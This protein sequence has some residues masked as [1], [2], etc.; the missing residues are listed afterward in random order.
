MVQWNRRQLHKYHLMKAGWH[1][2]GGARGVRCTVYKLRSRVPFFLSLR[3]FLLLLYVFSTGQ[4]PRTVRNQYGLVVLL[5]TAYSCARLSL[6]MRCAAR[7]T[8]RLVVGAQ[9]GIHF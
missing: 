1:R 2:G 3:C 6:A 4:S 9:E 8:V 7:R 5:R